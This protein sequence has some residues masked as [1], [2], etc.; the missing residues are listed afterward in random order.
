M[1][2]KYD[3]TATELRQAYEVAYGEIGAYHLLGALFAN[4]SSDV[5]ERLYRQ[6]LDKVKEDMDKMNVCVYCSNWYSAETTVCPE[7]NEYDGIMTVAT[8]KEEGIT[9]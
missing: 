2:Y 6:A 4:V 8:A 7:C 1:D 3:P 9:V 5:I